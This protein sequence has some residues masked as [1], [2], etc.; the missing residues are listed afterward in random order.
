MNTTG[1]NKN[2]ETIGIILSRG[3][4]TA[5]FNDRIIDICHKKNWHLL[6]DIYCNWKQFKKSRGIKKV[7]IREVRNFFQEKNLTIF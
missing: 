7:D 1:T 6:G 5:M 4:K 2:P 3:I